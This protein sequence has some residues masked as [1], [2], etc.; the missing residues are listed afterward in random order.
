MGEVVNGPSR[1]QLGKRDGSESGVLSAQFEIF[2]LQVQV[3][4]LAKTV[5]P[6]EGKFIEQL[7]KGL[8]FTLSYVSQAV[9]RRK[10]LTLAELQDHF[11]ARHPIGAVAVNQMA[12]D[13]KGAPGIVAFVSHRPLVGEI[14]QKRVQSSGGASKQRRCLLQ[15]VVHHAS[16]IGEVDCGEMRAGHAELPARIAWLLPLRRGMRVR[17]VLIAN[18]DSVRFC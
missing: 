1:E 16:R 14:A 18:Q 12:D 13:F 8:A 7:I 10:G 5:G 15:A 9:E 17:G 2:W 4:Q 11:C 3:A 6:H